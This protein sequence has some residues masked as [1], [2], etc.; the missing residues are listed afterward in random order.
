MWPNGALSDIFRTEVPGTM[1]ESTMGAY[2]E[3]LEFLGLNLDK[4][5]VKSVARHI[6]FPDRE[7]YD[8]LNAMKNTEWADLFH[9]MHG[10]LCDEYGPELADLFNVDY[11]LL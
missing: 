5:N 2:E 11:F 1:I 8:I 9:L 10:Y 6:E 3:Y 4:W 7:V